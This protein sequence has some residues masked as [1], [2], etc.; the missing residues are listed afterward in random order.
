MIHKILV[1][2]NFECSRGSMGGMASVTNVSNAH[3]IL[4]LLTQNLCSVI[5]S[6]GSD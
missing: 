1:L 5:G 3:D 6:C 4:F 2:P